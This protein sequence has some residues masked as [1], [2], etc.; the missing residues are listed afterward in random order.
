MKVKHLLA[1]VITEVY[2]FVLVKYLI[3]NPH[4]SKSLP[5]YLMTYLAFPIMLS[6]FVGLNDEEFIFVLWKT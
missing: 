6:Q 5:T 4:D 3:L 1:N 2:H